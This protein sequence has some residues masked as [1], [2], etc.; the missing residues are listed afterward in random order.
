[1]TIIELLASGVAGSVVTG[2]FAWIL[3]QSE[4]KKLR[5][6]TEKIEAEADNLVSDRLIRE[7]NV[8]TESNKNLRELAEQQAKDIDS[9]RRDILRYAAREHKHAIENAILRSE[10]EKLKM[11]E[12]TIQAAI[13]KVLIL[14]LKSEDNEFDEE[15]KKEGKD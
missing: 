8:I 13:K 11:P 2:L 5:A 1:M 15:I 7:L 6:E 9:L 4:L 10:L 12:S 3:R 14:D